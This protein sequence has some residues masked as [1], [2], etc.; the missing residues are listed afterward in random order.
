L[1]SITP[2]LSRVLKH[3]LTHSFVQQKTH[4][5]APTWLQEGLAQWMEGR[6]SDL[7]A[8][9]LLRVYDAKQALP[10]ARLEGSWM[11]FPGDKGTY[12]YAWSLA[13]V[14]MILR[15]NGMGDIEQLLD[16]IAAG[17]SVESALRNVVHSDY[18]E[19]GQSTA[20][21]LRKSYAH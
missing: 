17:E 19:L 8:V 7:N 11:Q 9:G 3:E 1:T 14:E 18:E 10:L 4:G 6:R 13:H 15:Q 12:A 20:E 5:R 21:Y 2:D 16:R